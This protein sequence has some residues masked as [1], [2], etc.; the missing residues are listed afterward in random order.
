MRCHLH[1]EVRRPVAVGEEDD[2]VVLRLVAAQVLDER[3]RHR[4]VLLE[5]APLLL[6]AV[7]EEADLVGDGIE[8]PDVARTRHR[9]AA[10][11]HAVHT[12]LAC[13]EHVLPAHVVGRRGGEHL[14]LVALGHVLGD[15][16]A[17]QLGAAHHLRPVALDDEGDL[18]PRPLSFS[19]WSASTR[20]RSAATST[21]SRTTSRTRLCPR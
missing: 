15:P 9:E 21:C 10:H 8:G 3:G 14:D 7:L 6:V 4:P 18:H 11:P 20:L 2:R 19:F 5:P 1:P 16:A 12:R 17:V 13:R